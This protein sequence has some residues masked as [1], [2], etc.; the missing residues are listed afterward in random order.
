MI[1]DGTKTLRRLR[2]VPLQQPVW[3][4]AQGRGLCQGDGR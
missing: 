1:I 2:Q 4:V 3:H